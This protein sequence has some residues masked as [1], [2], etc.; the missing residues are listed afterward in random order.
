MGSQGFTG[1]C[2]LS[3][4]IETSTGQ[5]YTYDASSY[6][7][8]FN[9]E[10]LQQRQIFVDADGIRGTRAHNFQRYQKARTEV[11]GTITFRPGYKNMTELWERIL[12]GTVAAGGCHRNSS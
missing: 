4:D 11:G 6:L 1:R 9:S 12:G 10:N 3:T 8:P 5:G 2:L 7:I